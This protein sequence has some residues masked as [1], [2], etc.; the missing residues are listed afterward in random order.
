V[1]ILAV[2]ELLALYQSGLSVAVTLI[3]K[4]GHIELGRS[5][6]GWDDFGGASKVVN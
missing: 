2:V 1:T 4:A 3:T 5:V 6:R